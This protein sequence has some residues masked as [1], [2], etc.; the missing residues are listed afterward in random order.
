M[1]WRALVVTALAAAMVLLS[2][3]AAA[4]DPF[5]P[6]STDDL[7]EHE[8]ELT[9]GSSDGVLGL[10]AKEVDFY[11]KPNSQVTDVDKETLP[12][13][14][15]SSQRAVQAMIEYYSEV[16][17]DTEHALDNEDDYAWFCV[18]PEQADTQFFC[19]GRNGD[20]PKLDSLL[21][22]DE[23]NIRCWNDS[24]ERQQTLADKVEEFAENP[25]VS[26]VGN[27]IDH[28][29]LSLSQGFRWFMAMM[30]YWWLAIP[31]PHLA[32]SSAGTLWPVMLSLS[33]L[34]GTLFLIARGVRMMISRKGTDILVSTIKG[35]AKYTLVCVCTVTFINA[36]S[37]F[38]EWLT[39]IFVE[40]GLTSSSCT[41]Y[42]AGQ[43]DGLEL[44]YERLQTQ[45]DIDEENDELG[46]ALGDCIAGQFMAAGMSAGLMI[47]LYIVALIMGLV[48][49]LLM[50]IREAALP[51][52]VLLLPI[53]ASGQIG[54]GIFKRWLPGLLTLVATVLLYK[55]ML[56]IVF[57][58]GFA[59]WTQATDIM[60]IIRG[61]ITL[62]IGVIAPGV[63]LKAFKPMMENAV[64]EG[65]QLG[66]VVNNAFL[67]SQ[68]SGTASQWAEKRG[69]EKAAHAA[70]TRAAEQ[71]AHQGGGMVLSAT[72]GAAQTASTAAA[73]T[74]PLGWMAKA[75]E[76]LKSALPWIGRAS[77]G[78]QAHVGRLQAHAPHGQPPGSESGLHVRQ[79]GQHP[80]AYDLPHQAHPPT[81]P[82]PAGNGPMPGDF[83]P[84]QPT[85]HTP[86][87][88]PPTASGYDAFADH[89]PYPAGG[90][91]PLP[92]VQAP[93][94]GT[95]RED[96]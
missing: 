78:P 89:D 47:I 15:P 28:L 11:C 59:D 48:Q 20:L 19:V 8:W 1:R 95:R 81:G 58:V 25:A 32:Q 5:D 52:M 33:V 6:H 83:E 51:I 35:L 54:G 9:P 43:P 65:T 38:S 21:G 49:A 86:A 70:R 92:H 91:R 30:L 3:G 93:D 46:R 71:L 29:A 57:A 31:H 26:V 4:A 16:F 69:Q 74:G 67:G 72:K 79:P 41:E 85:G 34:L 50:F 66:S 27:A 45:E 60:G 37:E 76:A 14:D 13:D 7:Q 17:A 61:M 22:P 12:I 24:N 56:A 94:P 90:Q 36:A 2:G 62:A 39:G 87:D 10:G 42:Q 96:E 73:A 80:D 40:M 23:K 64:E 53:A 68:L 88:V 75:G 77:Q 18:S 82:Q 55:P 44:D 84:A 63:M